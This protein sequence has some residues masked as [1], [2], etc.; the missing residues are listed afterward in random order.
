MPNYTI[1]TETE[2]KSIIGIGLLV[3]GIPGYENYTM[4]ELA[5]SLVDI[6][7]GIPPKID[8]SSAVSVLLNP[9][10]PMAKYSALVDSMGGIAGITIMLKRLLPELDHGM[11]IHADMRP[12]ILL[13]TALGAIMVM[14]RFYS[15]H[16]F[17][18]NGMDDWAILIAVVSLAMNDGID[19][20]P[21][22]NKLNLTDIE[23]YNF[24]T[25]FLC[26]LFS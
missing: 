11:G 25:S 14:L 9:A 17:L 19:T 20:T 12:I 21:I 3:G 5:T 1:P 6:A 8:L 2:L 10:G 16:L 26:V 7:E 15:R 18:R 23:Y 4:F 13:L 22:A 24:G